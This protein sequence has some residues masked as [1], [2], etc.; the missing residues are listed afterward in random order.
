MEECSVDNWRSPLPC[1]GECAGI[2]C[3][4]CPPPL[5]DSKPCASKSISLSYT[6][7]LH[8]EDEATGA[9]YFSTVV[10]FPL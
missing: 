2:L 5:Q 8:R 6:H 9:P 3:A 4:A 10:M 1:D 7:G